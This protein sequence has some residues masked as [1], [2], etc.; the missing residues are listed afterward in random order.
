[1]YSSPVVELTILCHYSN[2]EYFVPFLKKHVLYEQKK[3]RRLAYLTLKSE[4]SFSLGIDRIALAQITHIRP[5]PQNQSINP[6]QPM[7]WA[8]PDKLAPY[9]T[10]INLYLYS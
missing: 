10:G 4:S 8:A 9:S 2:K 6:T 3:K 7:A 1:V 5:P